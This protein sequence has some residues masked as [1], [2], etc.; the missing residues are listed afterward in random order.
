ML[1]YLARR[2]LW[3]IPTLIGITLAC[4]L[5]LR[6]AGGDPVRN[7]AEAGLRGQQISQEA[8]QALRKLYD[9]DKPWYVQYTSLVRRLV[10]LDLG[11]RWQDGRPILEIIGEALPITLLLASLSLV[12][13]YLIAVPLGVYSAV[14]Q[15]TVKD[16]LITL[17]LF[18]LYSLPSFWLGTMLIVFLASGKFIS[19]PWLEQ[20]ACFPLQGWH[21]FEGFERMTFWQ[22]VRDVSWHLILP[23]FTLTYPAFAVISRYMRAGMLETL[24]QDYVRTARAKGLSERAVVFGHAL[25]NGLIPIVTLL[26]MELPELISGA[27]IVESIF[28]VRGMGFVALEAIRL[29]DYPL[30]ITIVA[31]IAT[32]TMF[33][34]LLSDFLYGLVDP[35]IDLGA[36]DHG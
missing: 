7:Q 9:L 6:L 26:G 2:L 31:F 32:V 23:V 34:T 28:G 1:Q 3:M 13:A 24:R 10:T 14:A 8:L 27:V 25:R 21:A 15:H 29:P 33:S 36:K 19:C 20:S 22:K 11:N 35:R 17:L 12:L 16:K 30:V 4:F 5:L 18:V